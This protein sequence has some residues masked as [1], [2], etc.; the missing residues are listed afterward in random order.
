[1]N[2]APDEH[3]YQ[4]AHDWHHVSTVKRL[5]VGEKVMARCRC[6]AE[7]VAVTE[8]NHGKIDR[9]EL[10]PA[11]MTVQFCRETGRSLH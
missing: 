6:G 7:H 11:G 2:H 9:F 8:E 4:S 3:S 10:R 1:M 5:P